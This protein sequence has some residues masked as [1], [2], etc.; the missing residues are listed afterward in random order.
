M[1]TSLL[2]GLFGAMALVAFATGAEPDCC[3]ECGSMRWRKVCRLVP[4]TKKV[5]RTEW[6]VECEDFCLPAPKHRCFLF[7]CL[8][9]LGC[10][11]ACGPCGPVRTRKKYKKETVTEEKPGCKC[12]VETVCCQCGATAPK[13]AENK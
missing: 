4:E 1:K 5:T 11:D 9:C 7:G 8:R 3:P 6:T 10:R 12:V 2:C 13:P